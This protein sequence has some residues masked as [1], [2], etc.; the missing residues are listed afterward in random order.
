MSDTSPSPNR[1]ARFFGYVLLVVGGGI[2]LLSG[3]CTLG[4]AGWSMTQLDFS[5]IGAELMFGG[6][7]IAIGAVLF[8]LGRKLLRRP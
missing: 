3:L 8:W 7:P 4:F 2:L 5:S 1:V 6:P